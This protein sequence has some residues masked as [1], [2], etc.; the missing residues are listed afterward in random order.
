VVLS[1]ANTSDF[2]DMRIKEVL[3]KP[4][5]PVVAQRPPQGQPA[6]AGAAALS[7]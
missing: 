1:P 5:S 7:R 2:F 4:H 6:A 3:C